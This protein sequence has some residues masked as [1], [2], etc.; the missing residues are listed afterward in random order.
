MFDLNKFGFD[1][2]LCAYIHFPRSKSLREGQDLA[3]HA[4]EPAGKAAFAEGLSPLKKRT[5]TNGPRGAQ[6]STTHA[7]PEPDRHVQPKSQPNEH[8]GRQRFQRLQGRPDEHRAELA[9]KPEPDFAERDEEQ[10]QES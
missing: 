2:D 5:P 3:S 7:K 10:L 8:D 6:G 4:A 1:V 9:G